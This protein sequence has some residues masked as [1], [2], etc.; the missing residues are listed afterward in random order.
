[1][2]HDRVGRSIDYRLG[3]LPKVSPVFN[4]ENLVFWPCSNG[5]RSLD[6][7]EIPNLVASAF[8]IGSETC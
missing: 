5:K 3:N 7:H 6:G 4:G 1:M 8:T 2:F